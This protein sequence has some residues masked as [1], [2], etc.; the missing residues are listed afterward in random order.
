[1]RRVLKPG[2]LGLVVNFEP[3]KPG[4]LRMI[5][6]KAMTAMAHVDVREYVPLLVQAGIT[7]IDTGPTSSKQLSYVQGRVPMAT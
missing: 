7:D 4:L 3:P 2:G 1:M 6:E 5:V